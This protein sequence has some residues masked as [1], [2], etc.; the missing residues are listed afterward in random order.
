MGRLSNRVQQG[1]PHGKS[2]SVG[3]QSNTGESQDDCTHTQVS[4][5]RDMQTRVRE[6]TCS[7]GRS[8]GCREQGNCV[9]L[10]GSIGSS[11][12]GRCTSTRP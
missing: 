9:G 1:V 7:L 12:V 4:V 10:R 8:A 11:L 6:L 5:V 2:D 3:P